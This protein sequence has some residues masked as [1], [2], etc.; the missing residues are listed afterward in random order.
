MKHTLKSPRAA[1]KC[2]SERCF[3][4]QNSSHPRREGRDL[5]PLPLPLQV[6]LLLRKTT[7]Y[8]AASFHSKQ[9]SGPASKA[10]R[11]APG[12]RNK[13]ASRSKLF[14]WG[15]KATLFLTSLAQGLEICQG[16][17]FQ[18][19]AVVSELCCILGRFEQRI[20][21]AALSVQND[22]PRA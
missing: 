1:N 21:S 3:C 22:A 18:R 2:V 7:T 8:N 16:A 6:P 11:S 15:D 10:Q 12:L 9:N 20:A 14:C 17:W 5:L 4:S 19:S 13:K